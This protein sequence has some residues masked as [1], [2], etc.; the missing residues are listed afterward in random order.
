MRGFWSCLVYFDFAGRR[1]NMHRKYIPKQSIIVRDFAKG[2]RAA[3]IT[4]AIV[5]LNL[6]KIIE[7][8]LVCL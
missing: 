8:P 6:T 2:L 4:K 7:E 3:C 1:P 5:D